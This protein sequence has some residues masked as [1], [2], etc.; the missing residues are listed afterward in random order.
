VYRVMHLKTAR[1][2]ALKI[3][4]VEVSSNSAR[5]TF[6]REAKELALLS[7]PNVLTIHDIC[8]ENNIC[9]FVYEL[10]EGQTL[11]AILAK[12]PLS[13]QK[14]VDWTL[15]IANGIAAAHARGIVHGDLQ[16]KNLFVTANGNIKIAD[17]GLARLKGP[18]VG[19]VMCAVPYLSPEQVRGEE[20]D[21]RSDIFSLGCVL[22][23]MITGHTPFIRSSIVETASAI[24]KEEPRKISETKRQIPPELDQVISHCLEK[25]LC[26][27]FPSARDL[28][29][30]LNQVLEV[31]AS[32]RILP[33]SR[34]WSAAIAAILIV[35]ILFYLKFCGNG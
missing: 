19:D 11:Q 33:K 6:E 26:S 2:L 4:P 31:S 22:Y 24:L 7:H 14:A 13:W 5:Q 34:H 12:S 25:K 30:E 9:Y 17:F 29:F 28:I 3:L 32:N 27:R 35:A 20:V 15:Q 23:E 1:E 8:F 16:P 18:R 21:F 10:L